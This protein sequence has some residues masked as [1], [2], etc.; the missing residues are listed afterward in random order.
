MGKPE[1]KHTNDKVIINI[2]VYNRQKRHYL[3]KIAHFIRQFRSK[4]YIRTLN[5]NIPK[6][7]GL[8]LYGSKAPMFSTR[9]IKVRT[10]YR[11]V[12]KSILKTINFLKRKNIFLGESNIILNNIFINIGHS[13]YHYYNFKQNIIQHLIKYLERYYFAILKYDIYYIRK[14]LFLMRYFQSYFL[15]RFKF[16][17]TFLEPL[18]ILLTKI[19]NKKVTF[20]IIRLKTYYLDSEILTQI[21]LAKA[22]N[23]N[24][25]ILRILKSCL[26]RIKVPNLNPR[27]I[28]REGTKLTG[29]Q[30]V[31]IGEDT[32]LENKKD[33]LNQTLYKNKK[34]NI[35][36][37]M[38]T[39][40]N[41]TVSGVRLEAAGRLTKRIT[42]ARSI[43]KVKYVGTLKERASSYQ[44]ISSVILRGN[45]KS[46]TQFS[47]QHSKNKI[48][49]FGLKG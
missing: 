31:L 22:I 2:Y 4:H 36:D 37:Y 40:K 27:L 1:L 38:S 46:N 16:N 24:N 20:N 21:L 18:I 8:K 14:E 3:K 48:G 32:N 6:E 29:I 30:N 17:S 13:T 23:R 42:A 10:V 9:Y 35:E 43:F 25:K 5:K 47:K 41:K 44:G 12:G 34:I 33:I 15:N 45:I 49:S 19:Y 11:K 28:M 26:F 39:I 7:R